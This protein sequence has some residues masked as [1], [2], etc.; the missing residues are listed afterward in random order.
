MSAGWEVPQA[1]TSHQKSDLF[2][3]KRPKQAPKKCKPKNFL[4][5][6]SNLSCIGD[7]KFCYEKQ[8][9]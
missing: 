3:L 6:C 9:F 5:S 4:F 8:C 7:I 1:F 2:L